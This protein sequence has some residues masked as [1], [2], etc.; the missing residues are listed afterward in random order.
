MNRA[1]LD[2]KECHPQH[3]NKFAAA[4]NDYE[5]NPYRNATILYH[6]DGEELM[7]Y[8]GMGVACEICRDFN[9]C[10]K[11]R[12]ERLGEWIKKVLRE[13]KGE[14]SKVYERYH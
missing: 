14:W 2:D 1:E 4:F 3:W 10:D 9:P 6:Q 11:S 7:S 8:P 13:F 12:P 5:G